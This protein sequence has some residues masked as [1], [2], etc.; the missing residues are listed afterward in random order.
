MQTLEMLIILIITLLRSMSA[1]K[2]GDHHICSSF[3]QCNLLQFL[4]RTIYLHVIRKNFNY[5]DALNF[6][7]SGF[8]MSSD[9]ILFRISYPK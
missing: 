8:V 3:Y 4:L 5:G 1:L 7:F 9:P 6:F 2:K